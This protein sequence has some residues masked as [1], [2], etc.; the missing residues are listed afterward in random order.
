MK[1]SPDEVAIVRR[2]VDQSSISIDSLR[3]DVLDHLC[4]VVEIKIE[5]GEIFDTALQEALRELA[6]DGLN[7]I[8]RETVFLLNSWCFLNPC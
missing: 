5:R 6:P 7:E 3:D 1:L 8:Q 2:Q 4:C